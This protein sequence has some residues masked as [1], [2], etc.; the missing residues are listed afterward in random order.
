MLNVVLSPAVPNTSEFDPLSFKE[1]CRQAK[2]NV[3]KFVTER[4]SKI[5]TLEN[6]RKFLDEIEQNTISTGSPINLSGAWADGPEQ[7]A[8]LG[9][10]PPNSLSFVKL[11]TR[12]P[13]QMY[14]MLV[15]K[16]GKHDSVSTI[17]GLFD[18]LSSYS[19]S[20][21]NIMIYD[22]YLL[23]IEDEKITNKKD[24]NN[25]K[26][27]T[28]ETSLRKLALICKALSPHDSPNQITIVTEF[29]DPRRLMRKNK[30]EYHGPEIKDFFSSTIYT[31]RVENIIRSTVTSLRE[32]FPVLNETEFIIFDCSDSS[33]GKDSMEHDRFIQF[34]SAA[35]LISSAG[36]SFRLPGIADDSGVWDNLDELPVNLDNPDV[37]KSTE[38]PD[39]T[40]IVP[41]TGNITLPRRA[42]KITIPDV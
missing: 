32:L 39:S 34:A 22:K 9:A 37:K 40:F 35:S 10:I 28:H 4:D 17:E 18:K 30:W 38:L 20:T 8:S 5:Q 7:V 24:P 16:L 36:F 25:L 13:K 6:W 29:F 12:N 31:A 41:V 26:P 27:N 42:H 23:R 19:V 11:T 2:D 15:A 33:L 3:V 1:L 21:P 14:R